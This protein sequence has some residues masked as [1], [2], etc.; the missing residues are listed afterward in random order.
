MESSELRLIAIAVGNTRTRLG[1]FDGRT[2]HDPVSIA[3]DEG[4]ERLAD[5][6]IALAGDGAAHVVLASVNEPLAEPIERRLSGEVSGSVWRAGRDLPIAMP[7]TL[8]DDTT[9]GADRWLNALAAFG[10]A[11]QACVVV[12][13]G[14]AVTVDFVDGE[15]TFHGGAIAPGVR[16]MLGALASGADALPA[17]EWDGALP[18]GGPFGQSTPDAMLRGV[19]AS[20]QG[21]VRDRVEAYAEA[22]GAY[23]QVVATGGD[24]IALFESSDLIE[25]IVPD[26]Q[27]IGL[28][29]ACERALSDDGETLPE[30]ADRA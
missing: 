24:S 30:E 12:D 8:A 25:Q 26:L 2:L 15:G 7:N 10:R 27:L 3:N 6:A 1:R 5:S 17:V 22:F 9:V 16:M 20:V 21:L 23:P 28:Q 18:A 13:A 14:T 19:L 4:V 29:V 11:R